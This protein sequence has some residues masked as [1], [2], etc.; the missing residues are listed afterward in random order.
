M[1][2]LHIRI[3]WCAQRVGIHDTA[4]NEVENVEQPNTIINAR[5]RDSIDL[6]VTRVAR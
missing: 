1:N 2:T 4:A 5:L 6:G 3:R